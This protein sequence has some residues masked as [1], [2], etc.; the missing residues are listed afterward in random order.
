MSITAVINVG[1]TKMNRE[2]FE[3]IIEEINNAKHFSVHCLEDT[4]D[5]F[6][7]AK[8]E[9]VA[10]GLNV[11]KHRW[12]EITT[13]VYK[14]GEWFLGVRGVSS[15]FSESMDYSDVEI[16]CTA[17]EMEEIQITSYQPKKKGNQNDE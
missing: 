3:K 6:Y 17:F 1:R 12:Y 16:A 11:D 10:K 13:D 15:L 8:P 14:I 9:S 4:C 5:L 7:E 2:E